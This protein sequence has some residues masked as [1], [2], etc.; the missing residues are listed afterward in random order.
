MKKYIC[1]LFLIILNN[2]PMKK[3]IFTLVIFCCLFQTTYSQTGWYQKQSGTTN[4]LHDLY[5]I[6]ELTGWIVADTAKILKTTNGGLN[7]S[8]QQ[9]CSAPYPNLYTIKFANNSTGYIGAGQDF[10]DFSE[11][12]LFKSTD[13]GNSWFVTTSE[14]SNASGYYFSSISIINPNI[15]FATTSGQYSTGPSVGEVR[16]STN[17]G[18][19]FL[20]G[21]GCGAHLSISF[22]NEQT[23]WTS[24]F[25]MSDVGPRKGYILKTTNTGTNWITQYKD[26]ISPIRPN[27]IQFIDNNTGYA[28][29]VAVFVSPPYAKFLKTTNGGNN[30]NI[31]TVSNSYK[32]VSLFFIDANTGWLCGSAYGGDNSAI[33]RTTNGGLTWANQM[34]NVMTSLN[35]IFF[36]N[37]LTGYAVGNNGLIYKTVT[38]GVTGIKSVGNVIPDKYSL[39]QNYPNPFNPSTKIRYTIPH[40]VNAKIIVY[41]VTG[42][43]IETLVNEKQSPGTY[44]VTFDGSG[45]P[46]GI[47]FCRMNTKDFSKTIKISLVK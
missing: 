46:S 24:A 11:G 23:G 37:S 36:V 42:R 13:M 28:V 45:Y 1:I 25:Y 41:D 18:T 14:T 34:Q 7:W 8:I 32:S 47:Y 30:W 5:F 10:G 12:Y 44:E 19:N 17:G 29:G 4:K 43:E 27:K 16:K 26:T 35:N 15:I 9:I 22:I 40:T 20:P 3:I 33:S 21:Y 2:K 6:N 38:G 39:Y 31:S